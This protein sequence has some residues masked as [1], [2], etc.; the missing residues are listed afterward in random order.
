M[1]NFSSDCVLLVLASDHYKENDYIRD[2]K[3]FLELLNNDT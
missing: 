1:K 2:Y 3:K